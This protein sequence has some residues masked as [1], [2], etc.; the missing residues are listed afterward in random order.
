MRG[1]AKQ[2]RTLGQRLMD[3]VDCL[4]REVVG[5]PWLYV[6]VASTLRQ[7]GRSSVSIEAWLSSLGFQAAR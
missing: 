6:R 7:G 5:T 2:Y 3:N 4:R 1:T